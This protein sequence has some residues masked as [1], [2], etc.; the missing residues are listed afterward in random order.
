[1]ATK[2]KNMR[3]TSVDLVRAGANQEADICLYKSAT[4]PEA[5]ESPTSHETNIFKRFIAWLRENPTEAQDEPHNPIEKADEPADLETIYKTALA[6]SIR[7]IYEDPNL[8]STE[9]LSMVEKSVDQ[10][11]EKMK[12]IPKEEEF[13]EEEEIELSADKPDRFDEIEEVKKQKVTEVQNQND[14]GNPYHSPDG[15]FTSKQGGNGSKKPA[16]GP[17][18]EAEMERTRQRSEDKRRGT[19]PAREIGP[20]SES[21]K[22]GQYGKG[23][24]DLYNR[25]MYE[26]EDGS[27]STVESFSTNI[28]GKEVLLPTVGRDEKGNP[29]KWTEDEAIDHYF[30]TGE[31][32]GMFDTPEEATEYAERLHEEQADYYLGKSDRFDEIEEVHK[33]NH[34][35][36]T[37]G[38]FTTSR[39]G[40]GASQASNAMN[41]FIQTSSKPVHV[42]SPSGKM[43]TVSGGRQDGKVGHDGALGG[44][45][46]EVTYHTTGAKKPTQ[47]SKPSLGIRDGGEKEDYTR[48]TAGRKPNFDIGAKIRRGN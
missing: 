9:R 7:S 35:H 19:G 38:R 32:L 40:G 15:K 12:E 11:T 21:G 5:T 2:L 30:E 37:D 20:A 22:I 3:L 34:N 14:I 4:P 8:T 16:S 26:N 31:H 17:A 13:E 6:E 36:G 39:G 33:Y 28:D 48:G 42:W 41:R 43:T 1:M 45:P 27:I 25:P 24:I 23:N 18:Q 46:K 47:S 44:K 10:Y 29:V